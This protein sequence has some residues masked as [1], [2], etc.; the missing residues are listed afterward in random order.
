M[1]KQKCPRG[2][3]DVHVAGQCRLA[4]VHG[5]TKMP[6]RALRPGCGSS[7]YRFGAGFMEKQKCPRGHCDAGGEGGAGAAPEHGET[8]MPARALRLCLWLPPPVSANVGSMEKQKCPRGHCDLLP[9]LPGSKPCGFRL[10]D[11]E[12]KMPAR[13]LRPF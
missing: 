8:K 4:G 7:P 6:A 1:E 11:G 3:C 5:E 9:C 10:L 2:N 12:T 13:A